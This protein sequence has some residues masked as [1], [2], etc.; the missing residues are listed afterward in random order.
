[1]KL[2]ACLISSPRCPAIPLNEKA[3]IILGVL[4]LKSCN[5]RLIVLNIPDGFN[6]DGRRIKTLEYWSDEYQVAGYGLQ[7]APP[8]MKLCYVIARR[9]KTDEAIS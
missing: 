2:L 1:M 3:F 9:L 5:Y 6:Q 7:V 4:G 8:P